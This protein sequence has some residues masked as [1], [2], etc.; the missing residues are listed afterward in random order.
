[1]DRIVYRVIKF[2]TLI[3]IIEFN[4]VI[5]YISVSNIEIR[6]KNLENVSIVYWKNIGCFVGILVFLWFVQEWGK[7][8]RELCLIE[9]DKDFVAFTGLLG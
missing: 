3:I 9:F 8:G 1:M 7:V 2:D 4:I 5:E 6:T